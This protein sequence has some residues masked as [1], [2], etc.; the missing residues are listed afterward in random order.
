MGGASQA[1]RSARAVGSRSGALAATFLCAALA[2]GAAAAG[3]RAEPQLSQSVEVGVV[4]RERSPGSPLAERL[5]HRLG[6]RVTWKLPIV[7]GFAAEIPAGAMARLEHSG[8]VAAVWRDGLVSMSDAGDEPDD[9]DL[10]DVSQ[11]DGLPPNRVWRDV[12]GLTAVGGLYDGDDVAVAVLD[13]GV[14]PAADLDDTVEARVEFTPGQDGIDRFGH[15]THMA[16]IIAGDG[17]ASR[18]AWRGVAPDADLISIKVAGP[19]GATD[20][21]VV[22]GALQ[23]IVTNKDRFGIRVLNLSFGTDAA[24]PYLTDPL[25][26]AVERVWRAGILVVAAAGNRGPEAASIS[27]PADDPFVLTVGAADLRGTVSRADDVVAP[28]SSRGPTGDGVPKPDVVAPGMSI[29]SVRAPGSWAD[30][31]RPEARVGRAYFKGTGTSQAAAVVSGIA[32]LLYEADPRLTPDEAKAALVG[33]SSGLSGQPG[34]GHG[35]VDASR[36]LRAVRADTYGDAQINAP[37]AS[38]T[39]T[40]GIESSRGSYHVYSDPDGDGMPQEIS[41]ETDV[42]GNSWSAATWWATPSSTERWPASPW[43]ALV[44]EFEEWEV[45]PW[46]GPKWS[47]MVWDAAAWSAKHWSNSGWVAKHWS[48]RHWSASVWN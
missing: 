41:G 10:V 36:A 14:S 24:S 11:Y 12:V 42:L 4:V 3:P 9:D 38:A 40:G 48:A 45:L 23:W 43:S 27:K 8:L 15:G 5:V 44:G 30:L 25:N 13:T 39:G 1:R 20:V 28:F 34:A 16:G 31:N 46:F 18:G 2:T 35:L 33:T 26:A 32:A 19:D 17:S 7:G 37:Y 29:V 22:L 21:S 6:G 47:G